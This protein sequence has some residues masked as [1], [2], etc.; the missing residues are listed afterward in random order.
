MELKGG[1]WWGR[2]EFG[3]GVRKLGRGQVDKVEV[4]TQRRAVRMERGLVQRFL[5]C[6]MSFM[7]RMNVV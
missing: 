7:N 4:L 6:K 5:G 3:R 2:L 1:K